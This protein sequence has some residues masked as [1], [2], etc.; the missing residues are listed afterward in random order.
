M[1]FPSRKPNT[2][3][4]LLIICQNYPSRLSGRL[5]DFECFKSLRGG[6]LVYQLV[7]RGPRVTSLKLVYEAHTLVVLLVVFALLKQVRFAGRVGVVAWEREQEYRL[8]GLC[9][10]P[11]AQVDTKYEQLHKLQLE[12]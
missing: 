5:W 11:E 1:T 12:V 2:D 8:G 4:H 6:F 3:W 7:A 9:R 10:L